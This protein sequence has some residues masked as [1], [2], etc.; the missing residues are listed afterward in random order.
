MSNEIVQFDNAEFS[1]FRFEGNC[2]ATIKIKEASGK[3]TVEIENSNSS[4]VIVEHELSDKIL[5]VRAKAKAAK[6]TSG[7]NNFIGGIRDAVAKDSIIGF[8]GA[9]ANG[10]SHL[11]RSESV[12]VTIIIGVPKI[13]LS[14]D[15]R[16]DNVDVDIDHSSISSI[17]IHSKNLNLISRRDLESNYFKIK[18]DNSDIDFIAGKGLALVKIEGCN[19]DV[20]IRR[21]SGYK[22]VIKMIGSNMTVLGNIEGDSSFGK[23]TCDVDN[24]DVTVVSI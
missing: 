13:F 17:D 4:L 12:E 1:S 18:S 5:T 11:E 16:A 3:P 9:L 14:L 7:N 23:I 10:F 2:S 22:G 6:K 20:T 19:S 24:G 15:I 8:I 21:N